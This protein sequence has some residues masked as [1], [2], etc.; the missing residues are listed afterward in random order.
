[1]ATTTV[2]TTTKTPEQIAALLNITVEEVEIR[3]QTFLKK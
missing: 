3:K 1:M 2:E